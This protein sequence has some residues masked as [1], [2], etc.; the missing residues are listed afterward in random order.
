MKVCF[1]FYFWTN[2]FKS[3]LN[4][5]AFMLS[6]KNLW[7]LVLSRVLDNV[8]DIRYWTIMCVAMSE[9]VHKWMQFNTLHI[10]NLRYS[11]SLSH[12][13]YSIFIYVFI[14]VSFCSLVCHL[15]SLKCNSSRFHIK[16]N[17]KKYQW[18]VR[19]LIEVSVYR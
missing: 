8:N 14:F 1:S 15:T 13:L 18:I 6:P 2:W 5:H 3:Y 4:A 16:Y 10:A 19:M 9:S 11:L 12:D 7:I 17:N